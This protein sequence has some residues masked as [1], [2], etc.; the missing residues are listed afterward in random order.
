MVANP[1]AHVKVL[2]EVKMAHYEILILIVGIISI[3][4]GLLIIVKPKILPYLVGG[5]FVVVGILWIVRAFI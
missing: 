4:M 5:Y 3:L 2:E 1:L